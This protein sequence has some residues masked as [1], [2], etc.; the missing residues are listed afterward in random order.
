MDSETQKNSGISPLYINFEIQKNSEPSVSKTRKYSYLSSCIGSGPLYSLSDLRKSSRIQASIPRRAKYRAKRG[1]N[2]RIQLP[3]YIMTLRLGNIP[4][5]SSLSE[6]RVVLYDY[7]PIHR[8]WDL[9]KIPWSPPFIDSGTWRN[10]LSKRSASRQDM[11]HD[12]YFFGLANKYIPLTLMRKV[13]K[14]DGYL[15]FHVSK[16]FNP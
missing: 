2:R 9:E 8:L 14:E 16:S 6:M 1:A 5:T 3:P 10:S 13:P 12:L 4:S 7:F 11:K 15:T